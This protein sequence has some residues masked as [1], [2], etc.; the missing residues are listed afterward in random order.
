M[1]SKNK[2]SLAETH[3]EVAKQ[4]HP[5]KNKDLTTRDVTYGS[6]KRVWWKCDKGED[7]E[8]QT[9]VYKRSNGTGC[10]I[11]SGNIVVNS[12]CLATVILN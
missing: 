1:P 12:N 8:W 6:D 11:C 3:P 2:K 5:T 7:H 9:N 4:W 10:P